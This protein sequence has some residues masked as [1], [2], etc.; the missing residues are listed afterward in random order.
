MF[1]P[2]NIKDILKSKG[3]YQFDAKIDEFEIRLKQIELRK[4]EINE[5]LDN[6]RMEEY[7]K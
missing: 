5:E 3:L 1:N 4:E 7:N 2:S 6:L